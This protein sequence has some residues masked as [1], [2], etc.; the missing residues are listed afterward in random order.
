LKGKH[1]VIKLVG[2]LGTGSRVVLYG[3]SDAGD[4]PQHVGWIY[5]TQT[6]MWTPMSL[7]GAPVVGGSPGLTA[8]WTGKEVILWGRADYGAPGGIAAGGI[9]DPVSNRWRP[10]SLAGSIPYSHQAAWGDGRM[11]VWET[12]NK[13][14]GIYDPDTDMWATMSMEGA[15]LV[16]MPGPVVLW[17]GSELLVWGFGTWEDIAGRLYRPTPKGKY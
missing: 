5:E 2:A 14:G 9:L 6:G 16:T 1:R 15:P 17:I 8:V 3:R 7:Q 11:F 12:Y 4:A 10:M 13:P